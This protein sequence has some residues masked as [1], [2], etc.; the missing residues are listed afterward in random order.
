[1]A[2][3]QQQATAMVGDGINDAPAMKAA[4]IGIAMGSGTDVA[5][6]N[7]RCRFNS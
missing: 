5:L 2:L 7:C 1:M 4:S 3:N 6:R